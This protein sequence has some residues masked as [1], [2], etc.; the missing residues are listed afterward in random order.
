MTVIYDFET[1]A[2]GEA[3]RLYNHHPR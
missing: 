1:Q 2:K 3:H